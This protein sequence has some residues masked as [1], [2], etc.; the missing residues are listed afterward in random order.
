ML[1]S[2]ILINNEARQSIVVIDKPIA[3]TKNSAPRTD[4]EIV[5]LTAD[6]E[7][8]I[9]DFTKKLLNG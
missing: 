9:V 8:K 3:G 6:Q 5:K 4:R 1:I 2:R 7:R